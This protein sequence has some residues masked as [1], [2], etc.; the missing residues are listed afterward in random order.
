MERRAS[1]SSPSGLLSPS[2]LRN[3]IGLQD[4]SLHSEERR[5]TGIPAE[6]SHH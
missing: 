4:A 5:G 1:R 2:R 3:V 6:A